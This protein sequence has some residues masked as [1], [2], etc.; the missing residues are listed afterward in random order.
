MV[1][2]LR[3]AL[4][5]IA[6]LL[7]AGCND[8]DDAAKEPAVVNYSEAVADAHCKRYVRCELSDMDFDSC[9]DLWAGRLK[10]SEEKCIEECDVDVASQ[11]ACASELKT[12]ECFDWGEGECPDAC[13]RVYTCS[14]DAIANCLD[15]LCPI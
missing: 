15:G 10:E 1:S 2:E 6:F 11:E 3:R 5:A 12:L 8:K 4:A 9:F 14:D 7:V 13:M